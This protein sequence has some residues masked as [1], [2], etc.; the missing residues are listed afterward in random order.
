MTVAD[1]FF[2]SVSA[3]TTTGATVIVGL[4]D[5]SPGLLLWRSLLQWMGGLG[6]IAL[7]LFLLPFLRVGGIAY[8]KLESSDIE[9]RPFERFATYSISLISIYLMLTLACAVCYGFAGMTA[10]NALNTP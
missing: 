7:G 10:F 9:D 5:R 4:D 8:F 6:V 3:I 1:A 2:E